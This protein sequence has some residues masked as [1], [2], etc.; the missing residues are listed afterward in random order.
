[1]SEFI[2]IGLTGGIAAGKSTVSEMFDRKGALIIDADVISRCALDK[3]SSCYYKTLSAFG[4]A[5]LTETGAIDRAK[6]GALVFGSEVLRHKL[7]GLIHP[8]V[9]EQM[10]KKSRLAWEEKPGRMLLWDVPLLFEAGMDAGL[11]ANIL[12]TAPEELRIERLYKRDG[13]GRQKALA[14]I[15]S[16][17][18]E[19]EK[20]A[21]ADYILNNDGSLQQLSEQ[22]DTLY[23]L[24]LQRFYTDP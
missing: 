9:Y 8:F 19:E 22:V 12:V 13:Y 23:A 14:R 5:V 3:G 7:N 6:L 1:M 18:P 20:K 11:A 16:Q 17:M 15:R 10:I 21:K 24:L 4:D 2:A